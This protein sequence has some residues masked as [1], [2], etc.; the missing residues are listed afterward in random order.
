M[1]IKVKA[2]SSVKVG[3]S[4][5]TASNNQANSNPISLFSQVQ[6]SAVAFLKDAAIW[7]CFPL[8]GNFT[9]GEVAR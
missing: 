8:I 6:L 2:A 3:T 7:A 1:E 9:I 5:E 4:E